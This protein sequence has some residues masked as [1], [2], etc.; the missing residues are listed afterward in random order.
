MKLYHDLQSPVA[1]LKALLKI[2][3]LNK[4]LEDDYVK[5]WE[6]AIKRIEEILNHEKTINIGNKK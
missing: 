1:A 4:K 5:H 3:K 6:E 2:Y